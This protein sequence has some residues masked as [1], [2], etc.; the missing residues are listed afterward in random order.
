M[1]SA[2]A[3]S[4][5]VIVADLHR[6]ITGVSTTIRSLLPLMSERINLAFLGNTPQGDIPNVTLRQAWKIC[7]SPLPEGLPFRIWQALRNNEMFW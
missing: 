2:N 3:S 7:R 5:H 4:A 1:N 6:R